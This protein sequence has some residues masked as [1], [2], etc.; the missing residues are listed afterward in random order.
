MARGPG[1]RGTLRYWIDTHCQKK[2][3]SRSGEYQNLGLVNC[4][5]GITWGGG[6]SQLQPK[7][8]M[9]NNL[10]K[11]LWNTWLSPAKCFM[12]ELESLL[13]II[14]HCE[15][16]TFE[17]GGPQLPKIGGMHLKKTQVHA[18]SPGKPNGSLPLA[19]FLQ[20]A[21]PPPLFPGPGGYGLPPSIAPV[22]RRRYYWGGLR[23]GGRPTGR[24]GVISNKPVLV[25][26]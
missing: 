5:E 26:S 8:V 22:V 9:G 10:V 20:S 6:G 25:T 21:P 17:G 19:S 13:Y 23:R 18:D 16:T 24:V 7:N 11:I 14:F 2:A 1:G 12:G 15:S 3:R 4:F